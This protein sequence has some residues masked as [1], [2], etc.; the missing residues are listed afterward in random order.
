LTA[1]ALWG[2]VLF[3]TRYVSLASI[4]AAL[5]LPF[6]VWFWGSSVTMTYVMSAISLLAI[7]KHAGNIQ[8]LFK[9]EENRIG[10]KKN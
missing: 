8:R 9:G 5:I 1:L 3:L 6:A 2:C 7:Y 4:A 10:R